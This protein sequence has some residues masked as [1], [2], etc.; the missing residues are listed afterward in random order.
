MEHDP[1]GKLGARRKRKHFQGTWHLSWASKGE[2]NVQ[3]R[4]WGGGIPAR[5]RKVHTES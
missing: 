4:E 2:W 5:R 3:D 1:I